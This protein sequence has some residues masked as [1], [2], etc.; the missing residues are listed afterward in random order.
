MTKYRIGIAGAGF[1]VAAHLPAL[2]NHPRFEVVALASPSSA[3]ERAREA[4]IAAFRSCAEMVAAC[5]L[6]AVTVASPPFAHRD[7]VLAAL[8]AGK[9]VL[10]EKPF[11][12]RLDD[13]RE[14][15]A[16]AEA[17]GTAC[18]VAHE[19]RF[20]PQAQALKEL[21]VNGHL[22]PLRNVEI[23]LLRSN[24]RRHERRP[25][26]WWFERERGGGLTGAVVSHMVDQAN[27][28][29]GRPPVRAM[30]FRRTANPQRLD[31]AGSFVSSADDGAFALLDYGEGLAARIAADATAAV[32]SYTCA[33]HGEKRTAVASG[34]TIADLTLYTIDGDGTD[35]LVCKPL[36]Y[37]AFARINPNV[38]LLMEL[39]DEFVKKI[40]GREN[41]LP[42]FGEALATQETL[43]AVGYEH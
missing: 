21:A 26:S 23:T 29:A 4:G 7:D 42:T 8:A 5:D 22:D 33:L 27:W 40:E 9:H 28:L 6:D 18:G 25:R 20:V 41:E 14:M 10:C 31:E 37:A 43:A 19:F 17:A 13:A 34:P 12:L 1:G 16:A 2:R 36:P 3:Q 38:P 11:A 32:E 35:E 15:V 30:G 24:L 39:Y